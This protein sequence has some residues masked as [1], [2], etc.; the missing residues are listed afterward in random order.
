MSKHSFSP[1]QSKTVVPTGWTH[2]PPPNGHERDR[3]TYYRCP[4]I[5]TALTQGATLEWRRCTYVC[6]KDQIPGHP[7]RLHPH[8]Y[9]LSQANDPDFPKAF[10]N[11]QTEKGRLQLRDEVMNQIALLALRLGLNITQASA[12]PM[13]QFVMEMIT[14]GAKL[15]PRTFQLDLEGVLSTFSPYKIRQCIVNAGA[16]LKTKDMDKAKQVTFVNIACDSGT[17]LGKTVIHALLTNPYHEAFPMVLQLCE[18]DHLTSEGYYCLFN[19]LCEECFANDLVVC[20]IVIDNLKAQVS[21]LKHFLRIFAADPMKGSIKH[22]PCFA[23][24]AN[25]VFIHA[26]KR[27]PLLAKIVIDVAK[28]VKALRKTEVRKELGEKCESICPTRWLYLVD[29]LAWILQR[30]EKINVFLLASDNNETTMSQLPEEWAF[31]FAILKP[32][33]RFSLCVEASQ[34]ALWEVKDLVDC[35][36]ES[37]RKVAEKFREDVKEGTPLYDMFR[38]VV[39][40]FVNMVQR[41]AYNEVITSY[42]LSELGREMLRRCENGLQTEP[43]GEGPPSFLSPRVK[44]F[45][46]TD[47]VEAEVARREDIRHVDT[48]EPPE[49][50][51]DDEIKRICDYF[52]QIEEEEE[53]AIDSAKE[54]GSSEKN[55]ETLLS[56]SVYDISF[57]RAF[58]SLASVGEMQGLDE[59]YIYNVFRSW[60]FSDRAHSPTRLERRCSPDVI[61]RRAPAHEESWRGISMVALRYV[62]LGASEADCERSLSAQKNIQGLHT[63]KVGIDLLESRLRARYS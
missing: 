24:M 56:S 58:Q 44:W 47:E 33:K 46:E 45:Q 22:V 50:E 57:E 1:R 14:L 41:N 20:G 39:V 6:R 8:R 36:I 4:E 32:L 28:L 21:G 25:L 38:T 63:T 52:D 34:C 60:L 26:A 23:H 42:S 9:T 55:L 31:C 61:W 62:T 2:V 51:E 12:E 7:C 48:A 29:V 59:E 53:E 19:E 15:G 13:R 3:H 49:L 40:E 5:G 17:V 35:V 30:E 18:N 10:L 54:N 43:D 16:E 37:W 11:K 27:S